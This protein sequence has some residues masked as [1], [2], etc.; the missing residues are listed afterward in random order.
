MQ[1]ALRRSGDKIVDAVL[2]AARA[3]RGP[4]VVAI[5]GPSGA[6][7]SSLA[8]PVA[9]RL[10]ATVIPLDD[11]FAASISNAQSAPT[12]HFVR[13]CARLRSARIGRCHLFSRRGLKG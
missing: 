6:G 2:R 1:V 4:L 9:K 3:H 5:D 11:F 8:I 12:A 7:K 13:R 10:G